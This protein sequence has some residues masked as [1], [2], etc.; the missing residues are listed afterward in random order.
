M[1]D[2]EAS[3]ELEEK[4]VDKLLFLE[5]LVFKFSNFTTLFVIFLCFDFFCS[6]FLFTGEEEEAGPDS[7]SY[8]WS[9][10]S[11]PVELGD[12]LML[13]FWLGSSW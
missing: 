6:Y 7:I 10:C 9:L 13:I 2:E 12:K 3:S 8:S 11:I 1:V 4:E 5:V